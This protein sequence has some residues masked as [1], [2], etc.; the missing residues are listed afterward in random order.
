[1]WCWGWNNNGQLGDGS[2][3]SSNSLSPVV[4]S[5]ERSY[6][7][8][9]VGLD[10]ACAL[11]SP[12]GAAWCWGSNGNAQLGDNSGIDRTAPV[13]VSGGLA[14]VAIAAGGYHTCALAFPGGAAW[15]W[16]YNTAGQVG[17]GTTTG[18]LVPVIV[19]WGRSYSAITAGDYHTCALAS[20]GGSVGGVAWCWGYNLYGQVG[21]GTSGSGSDRLVPIAV[22]GARNYSTISAGYIHTCALAFPG[23]AAWCWGY[24][25]YGQ[26]GDGTKGTN[27]LIPVAVSGGRNYSALAAGRHHT[28]AIATPG[29]AAWCWGRNNNGQLGDNTT[30]DRLTPVIISGG[31]FFTEI[32]AGD[33]HTCASA[34]PGGAAWCWGSNSNGQLGVVGGA[35]QLSPITVMLASPSQSP[36]PNQTMSRSQTQTTS[37]NGTPSPTASPS[38][39]MSRS[40]SQSFSQSCS[41]TQT[42]SLFASPTQLQTPTGTS[43]DTPT[44]SQTRTATVTPSLTT[45]PTTSVT[46]T[47]TQVFTLSQSQSWSPTRTPSQTLSPSPSAT[48][49]RFLPSR[50][51]SLPVLRYR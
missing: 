34:T 47:Q 17:D 38:P 32:A 6:S 21:D 29:G 19:I 2:S 31:L 35:S 13:A 39:T 51:P 9:A 36:S 23:G 7:A 37:G 45:S 14:F 40:Q 30:T 20:V 10:H 11:V 42:L 8:L 4:V 25:D 24:N 12:G 22:S 43:A 49:V 41:P 33:V 27:R 28:C 16:G 48:R 15:C 3:A 50:I 5:W 26:V 18:T 44:S 1:V 46:R